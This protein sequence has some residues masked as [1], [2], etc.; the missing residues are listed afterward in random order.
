MKT[1]RSF[2]LITI[3]AAALLAG[4]CE[5]RIGID[6]FIIRNSQAAPRIGDTSYVEVAP[7]FGLGE[8]VNPRAILVGNDQ[9]IYVADYD[10]NEVVMMDAGGRV[11]ERI[12]I[13]HPIS[14]AQNAKLDLYIGGEATAPTQEGV[15]TVGAIYRIN[16]VRFD[17]SYVAWIDTTIGQFGDTIITPHL[18]DTSY[19]YD[20]NLSTSHR[21]IVW[22]EPAHPARRFVGIAIFPTNDYLVARAGPDNSSFTDQDCRILEFTSG[23]AFTTAMSELITLP[24]GGTGIIDIRFLTSIMVLPNSIEGRNFVLTQSSDGVAFG[25]IMMTWVNNKDQ[26]GWNPTYDPANPAQRNIDFVQPYRFR[27]GNA[28]G[29]AYDRRRKEL[30]ILDSEQDSIVKFNS[31][32]QFRSESFGKTLTGSNG[33]KPLNHPMGIAFSND[34]TLYIVDTG[35]QAIR[36]FKLSIQTQS[37]CY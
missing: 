1:L 37:Q 8:F 9:L 13:P 12:S 14:I 11:L 27:N 25:A 33:Y 26:T 19:Y 31:L 28:V 24:S 32:G 15:D 22:W 36:R 4:G 21:R 30:F 34:C 10:Q 23:D 17:T 18:R 16:L 2:C 35:N 7:W 20:H 29:T 6:P 3:T 5:Q